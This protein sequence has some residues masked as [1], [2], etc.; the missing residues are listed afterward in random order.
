MAADSILRSYGDVS[1]KEDVVLNALEILT[2]KE[3][4]IFN[5]LGKTKAIATVHSFL[6]DTLRTPS[7][8]GTGE[9]EDYTIL[10]SSTPTRLT[11]IVQN[12]SIPFAVSKTQQLVEHYQG[13]DE[14]SRQTQKALMDFANEAEFSILRNSLVSGVSGTAPKMNGIIY[15]ISKSTNTTAHTSG[16]VF[17]ATILDALMKNCWDNSNGNVATE[18]YVGSYLRNVIDLFTQKTNVVVNNPGGQT[19]IVRRVTTYETSHG[20]LQV[21]THRYMNVSGTDATGRVLGINPDMIKV[22][23]LESPTIDTGLARSGD[24]EKRAVKGKMTVEVRNQDVNFFASG[25]G[26]G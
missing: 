10:A 22:A 3:T 15:A 8:A 5:K 12:I 13:Q 6:V 19:T 25:F 7:G 9:A 2:A 4:Q 1:I 24:Y 16:T 23:M 17:S 20:T 26:I 18:L 14:L 11:N 21:Y